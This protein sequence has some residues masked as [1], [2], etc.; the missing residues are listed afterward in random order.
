M[1]A[2]ALEPQLLSEGMDSNASEKTCPLSSLQASVEQ[3]YDLR[4]LHSHR[5]HSEPVEGSSP[6]GAG[7]EEEEAQPLAV[8]TGSQGSSFLFVGHP[9]CLVSTKV[10]T[11]VD[12]A[13]AWA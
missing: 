8:V 3:A 11:P 5:T 13:R 1:L 2:Q 6:S 9:N 7:E 4:W 12:V 10:S